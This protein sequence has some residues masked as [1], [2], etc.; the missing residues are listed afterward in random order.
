MSSTDRCPQCGL[1]LYRTGTA[2]HTWAG[3]RCGECAKPTATTES[4]V[5]ERDHTAENRQAILDYERLAGE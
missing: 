5:K 4:A 3:W 1:S 2:I